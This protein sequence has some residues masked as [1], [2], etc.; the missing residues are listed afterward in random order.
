MRR[1]S[2]LWLI[3]LVPVIIAGC[4][5]VQDKP[6]LRL[7]DK[8]GVVD[9][10]EV[11]VGYVNERL[12]RVPAEM[13]P[14]TPGDEGKRE[15]MDEIVKKELLVIYGM[16]LGALEDPRYEPAIEYFKN[17]KAEEMLRQ[18][19][20]GE[21]SQV[22]PEE[23]IDYYQV[24]DDLFQ[25]QEILV[26]SEEE[27]KEVYKRVTE[28]GE[29]FGKV[30]SQVSRSPSASD[31]GRK[32]VAAWTELH[33][34]IRV[35]VRYSKTG[36]VV[37]P[38][39]IGETW[40]ILKVL[41][42]KDPVEQAPL[43]GSHKN[44][45]TAEA[46]AFKRNILE[47]EVFKDWRDASN[48]VFNDDAVD[49]CGTRIDDQVRELT[50]DT[51]TDTPEASIEKART[52][53]IPEFTD[54]EAKMVL[55]TYNIFGDEQ[56]VTLGDFAELCREA[57]GIETPKSGDRLQIETFM[58]RHIQRESID[59]AVAERGF[60]DSPEM[61]KYVEQRTEE[62][63]IDI[64]YDQE[65]VQKAQEPTGQEIRDYYR[66]HRDEYV[67]PAG[68]DVQQ[69]IVSTEA[70]ANRALQRL[71]AG[72]ATFTD[73]VHEY[74]IDDWSKAKDGVIPK[75]RVGEKRLDYLQPVVF[76]MEV[77]EV[78]GPIRAPGGYALVKVIKKYPER[79]LTFDEVA[80]TV[81]MSL[82]NLERERLLNE[83]LDKA[84]DTVTVDYIDENFKYIKDPAEVLKEKLEGTPSA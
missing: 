44:G 25:L 54:E 35:A 72:E 29:D 32:P 30:A 59:A 71:N 84:R 76:D 9:P 43:E 40:F 4:S 49:L 48:L 38:F 50:P 78:A 51:S 17:N 45:I 10:R 39:P 61:E 66:S 28:G 79:P 7:T 36:D 6:I 5:S 18:E 83:L 65:V 55:C 15:F 67:E 37:E 68:V 16:R 1:T 14:D 82:T 42:R 75:Y 69:M 3:A 70:V 58:K 24:R 46:R 62:F 2:A 57:P 33:P 74:S 56:T 19:L 12:D 81:K 80:N 41:S 21:P 26:P 13:I 60:M 63:V 52:P 20:I 53:I 77:G 31:E 47:Y 23:V 64:T 73:L 34:L 11:T 22:T 8:E 27:A